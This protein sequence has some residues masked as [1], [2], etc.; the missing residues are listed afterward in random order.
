VKKPQQNTEVPDSGGSGR[1]RQTALNLLARREHS[2]EELA[3]KLLGRGFEDQE[4]ASIVQ[5]LVEQGLLSNARF[6]EQYIHSRIQRGFGPL[7]ILAELRER[8]VDGGL[9][10]PKLETSGEVWNER[11]RV[12][13]SKRFGPGMPADFK[14]RARQSRFL[15]QRGYTQDQIRSALTDSK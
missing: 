4:V 7:R 14:E 15:Q 12:A 10:E 2:H 11:A 13:R 1:L 8:G 9:V 5:E 3:R 6:V